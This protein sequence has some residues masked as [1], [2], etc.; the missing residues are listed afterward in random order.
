LDETKQSHAENKINKNHSRPQYSLS[1]SHAQTEWLIVYKQERRAFLP[2]NKKKKKKER[3]RERERG[4]RL[5]HDRK[6][7]AV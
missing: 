1:L 6:A 2:K 7:R 5:K 3:E 4:E